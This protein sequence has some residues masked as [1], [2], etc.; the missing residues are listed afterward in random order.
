MNVYKLCAIAGCYLLL[1]TG[2]TISFQIIDTHG[3]ASDVVDDTASTTP[4]VSPNVNVPVS[5]LPSLPGVK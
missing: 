2:C 1:N 3:S 5:G 4:T